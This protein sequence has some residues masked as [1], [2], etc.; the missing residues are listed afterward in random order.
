M[1]EAFYF[2]VGGGPGTAPKEKAGTTS[3]TGQQEPPQRSVPRPTSGAPVGPAGWLPLADVMGQA[4]GP[5]QRER[6][7]SMRSGGTAHD[8]RE[9]S[10]KCNQTLSAVFTMSVCG[11]PGLKKPLIF[12]SKR[13]K[14]KKKPGLNSKK[15][16]NE[17]LNQGC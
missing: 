2:K 8:R 4:P 3:R 16:N 1:K 12:C 15:P 14:P 7:S 17:V 13:K 11:G 10:L 6:V 9:V 5:S